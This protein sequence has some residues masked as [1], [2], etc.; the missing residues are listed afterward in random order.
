MGSLT[1]QED[2]VKVV[3]AV[4][5]TSSVP[6]TVKV[7]NPDDLE[8]IKREL[9]EKDILDGDTPNFYEQ[10]GDEFRHAID[11]ITK[12]DVLKIEE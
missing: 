12:E 2:R 5:F 11:K 8:E 3:V 7:F 10:W 4:P 9:R 6:Y 1:H